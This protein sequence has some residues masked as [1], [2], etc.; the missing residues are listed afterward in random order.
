MQFHYINMEELQ[1]EDKRDLIKTLSECDDIFLFEQEPIQ[2]II[3]Y[4]WNTYARRFFMTQ[5]IMYT[6]FIICFYID[7]EG[8]KDLDEDGLRIKG[9]KFWFCRIVCMIVQ[10]ILLIYEL[11]QFYFEGL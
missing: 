10:T 8:L 9:P 11:F 2:H 4:K 1:G 6:I 3:D 7:M 5:F